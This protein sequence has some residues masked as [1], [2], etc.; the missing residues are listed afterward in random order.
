M[1]LLPAVSSHS[2]PIPGRWSGDT[3]RFPHLAGADAEAAA[4]AVRLAPRQVV[5]ADQRL[6]IVPM[7]RRMVN[8]LRRQPRLRPAVH[9]LLHAARVRRVRPRQELHRAEAAA[10]EARCQQRLV[11]AVR[12]RVV[13]LPTGPATERSLRA[14]L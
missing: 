1:R 11:Q 8:L 12:P 13:A 4:V 3:A 7:L 14:F 2:M 6:P 5:A 9:R 10:V